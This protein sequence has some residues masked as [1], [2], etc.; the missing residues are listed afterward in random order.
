MSAYLGLTLAIWLIIMGKGAKAK[1]PS[2]GPKRPRSAYMYF[3]NERRVALREEKPGMSITDC[4][5]VIGGEWKA[6][7]DE[8]KQ[9]YAEMASKDR[10][11]YNTEKAA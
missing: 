4:S 2:D 8:Q 7:T 1:T 5:K 3:S 11:R 9:P 10:E 6:L